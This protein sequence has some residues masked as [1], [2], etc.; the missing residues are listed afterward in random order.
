MLSKDSKETTCG[1]QMAKQM[2][3]P[4]ETAIHYVQKLG[5]AVN[6]RYL[7]TPGDNV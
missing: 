5:I 4:T 2:A 7:E 3:M 6:A 1:E